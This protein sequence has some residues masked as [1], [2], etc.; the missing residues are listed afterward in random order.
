MVQHTP[1]TSKYS[2]NDF[3]LLKTVISL[4]CPVIAHQSYSPASRAR[5]ADQLVLLVP[6]LVAAPCPPRQWFNMHWLPIMFGPPNGPILSNPRVTW[7]NCKCTCSSS[8]FGALKCPVTQGA[9]KLG[10]MEHLSSS[11]LSHGCAI[12][13]ESVNIRCTRIWQWYRK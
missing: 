12:D 4:K 10:R 11:G 2:S 1:T 5:P 6:S 7:S 8:G 9:R 13:L 3:S